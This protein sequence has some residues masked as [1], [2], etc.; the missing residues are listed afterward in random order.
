M[1]H[2]W[3]TCVCHSIY[4]CPRLIIQ[5]HQ[6]STCCP[7]GCRIVIG[8]IYSRPLRIYSTTAKNKREKITDQQKRHKAWQG[9][10]IYFATDSP[11]IVDKYIQLHFYIYGPPSYNQPRFLPNISRVRGILSLLNTW[12]ESYCALSILSADQDQKINGVLHSHCK[13]SSNQQVLVQSRHQI[14]YRF[15]ESYDKCVRTNFR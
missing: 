10:K 2:V 15:Q 14:L 11:S 13:S 4:V 3:L 6:L 7:S 5:C 1:W 8:R 12:D 9:Q